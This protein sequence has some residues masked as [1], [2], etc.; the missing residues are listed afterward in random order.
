MN[1]SVLNFTYSVI[2]TCFI[3]FE[4]LKLPTIYLLLKTTPVK[5]LLAPIS[6]TKSTGYKGTWNCE[7]WNKSLFATKII[8]ILLQVYAYMEQIPRVHWKTYVLA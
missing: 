7:T 4:G 3:T 6:S 8:Q 2:K 1:C 5:I